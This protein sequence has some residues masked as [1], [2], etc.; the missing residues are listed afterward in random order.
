MRKILY[1]FLS[2]IFILS[3]TEKTFAGNNKHV[4]QV[5]I[6]I[7]E[8]EAYTYGLDDIK[9][10]DIQA[11]L[12]DRN[13]E[14]QDIANFDEGVNYYI[15]VDTSASM[16]NSYMENIKE[17][18]NRLVKVAFKKDK[19][20]IISFGTEVIDLG[21]VS[22][23]KSALDILN[24]ISNKD[25][26]TKLFEA[27]K[28]T[29]NLIG[30]ENDI[31]N[32]KRNIIAVISDGE[33]FALGGVKSEEAKI[34]LDKISVPVYA[35]CI[36]D[37]KRENINS[38][39]EFANLT[40]GDSYIYKSDNIS[41]ALENL[42]NRIMEA[43]VIKFLASDNKISNKEEKFI[44]AEGDKLPL[45]RDVYVFRNIKDSVEPKVIEAKQI[46]D[47][48]IEIVFSEKVNGTSNIEN[49]ILKNG[50]DVL[51]IGG[52]SKLEDKENAYILTISQKFKSAKYMLS[53][54]D[55]YDD[56]NEKNQLLSSVEIE[57]ES[58]VSDSNS[59]L[60]LII[61]IVLTAIII[62]CIVSIRVVSIYKKI[63]RNKGI[64]NIN[65]EVILTSNDE[66]RQHIKVD[67]A[68]SKK[69][70]LDLKVG[71]SENKQL[72]IYISSYFIVGRSKEC[73]LYIDDPKMSRKHFIFEYV[74]DAL[75][76]KDLRSTNGTKVNGDIINNKIQVYSGDI[77]S[78]G[79]AEI[80][81]NL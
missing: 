22:D 18:I 20:R 36:E 53:F 54:H 70:I 60:Y 52:V 67:S 19:I 57:L 51:P 50:N 10:S 71:N 76:V 75:Y 16:P 37:T 80:V 78:I 21:T 46:N 63:K 62:L 15:L 49:Y 81:V 69:I 26:D 9:I 23:E 74:D 7:P 1:I 38:F 14:V 4:E 42:H 27:I 79:S 13:L 35:I 65:D 24:R 68:K 48:Q 41:E 33:D 34:Y 31:T 30:E 12:G 39:S 58:T 8:I 66:V 47:N 56:S 28:F 32:N 61:I 55:I 59:F 29:A 17:S 64:V 2:I 44:I 25:K 43:K 6:N 5:Y 45:S 72:E 73:N 11:K 40:F 77:I 3:I